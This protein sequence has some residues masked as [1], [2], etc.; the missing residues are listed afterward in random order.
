MLASYIAVHCRET[1][2]AHWHQTENMQRTRAMSRVWANS[3]SKFWNHT[4]AERHFPSIWSTKSLPLKEARKGFLT[5]R[6]YTQTIYPREIDAMPCTRASM[7]SCKVV[8]NHGF[9]KQSKSIRSLFCFCWNYCSSLLEDKKGY[10]C[11]KNSQSEAQVALTK[12]KRD[13][14]GI[15]RAKG[16][17]WGQQPRITKSVTFAICFVESLSENFWTSRPLKFPIKN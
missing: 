17:W 14:K 4:L 5:A 7:C 9:L 11:F 10:L 8:N 1:V 3:P 6:R 15:W 12:T 13:K 16:G 2:I